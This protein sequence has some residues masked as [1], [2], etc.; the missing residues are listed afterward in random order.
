MHMAKGL[1]YRKIEWE[2]EY[3]RALAYLNGAE[4]QAW[5]QEH[6][7]ISG[8]KTLSRLAEVSGI[9][10]GTL[11]KY[12]RQIQRP[13]VD[14]VAILCKSLDVAPADLLYG[15]GAISKD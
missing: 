8:L 10:K 6:L 1:Q 7:D 2:R 15:L 4:S 9:N 12:F 3:W 11:S 13:T 14:V 5:L